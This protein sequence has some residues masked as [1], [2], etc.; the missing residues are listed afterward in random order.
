MQMENHCKSAAMSESE[1]AEIEDLKRRVS[2]LEQL[3][4]EIT[5]CMNTKRQSNELLMEIPSISSSTLDLIF[6][7]ASGYDCMG[8]TR[9]KPSESPRIQMKPGGDEKPPTT[10]DQ[11]P[12]DDKSE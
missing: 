7:I 3:V 1:R 6:S 5:L 8:L 9:R 4:L 11:T 2:L 12:K 10:S